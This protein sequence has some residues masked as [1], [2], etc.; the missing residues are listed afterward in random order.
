VAREAMKPTDGSLAKTALSLLARRP[1]G[2]GEKVLK[3]ALRLEKRLLYAGPVGLL[4]LPAI[5]WPQ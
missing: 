4:R 5:T 1:P 3:V 2:G